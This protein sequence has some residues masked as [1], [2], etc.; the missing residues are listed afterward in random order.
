MPHV[1][2]NLLGECGE[3]KH[4]CLSVSLLSYQSIHW[5]TMNFHVVMSLANLSAGHGYCNVN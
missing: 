5:F 2:E 3:P 1:T 4:L